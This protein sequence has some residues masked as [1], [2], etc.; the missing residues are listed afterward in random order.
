MK[1]NFN[2]AQCFSI[3]E[4]LY[5]LVS[6]DLEQVEIP[7]ADI[8]VITLNFRDLYYSAD[9]GGYH[10]IELRLKRHKQAW[11]LIYI[12]DFSFQGVPFPE[13]TKEINIC[14]ITQ[15][16]F[17][18]FGGWLHDKN[19]NELVT[20]FINNFIEYHEMNVYQTSISFD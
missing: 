17:S 12:T 20:T 8:S 10:P 18:L 6:A 1:L 13:L 15:R 16:V 19:G 7:T 4:K 2:K 9:L 5:L 3:P 11:H 14:F